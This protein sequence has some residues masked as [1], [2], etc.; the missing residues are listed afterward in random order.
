MTATNV[1]PVRRFLAALTAATGPVKRTK[2][3]WDGRCPVHDDQRA[4]LSISEGDDGKVILFCHVGCSPEAICGALGLRLGDLF[5]ERERPTKPREAVYA[6]RRADGTL[7]FEVVRRVPKSFLQRR[8]DGKGG[9]TW[10]LK[11]LSDE[12]R[13]LPFRLPEIAKAIAGGAEPE[14][15]IVEGEKDVLTLERLGRLATCNAQGAGKFTA[16][17]ARH[18]A[19]VGV[20]SARVIADRDGPGRR[21]AHDVVLRLRTAGITVEGY[22][23]AACSDSCKDASDLAL[24][25]GSDVGAWPLEWVPVPSSEDAHGGPPAV[26]AAPALRQNPSSGAKNGAST[27]PALLSGAASTSGP[28]PAL[29]ALGLLG[30]VAR[31]LARGLQVHEELALAVCLGALAIPCGLGASVEVMAG[32]REPAVIFALAIADPSERKT[33]LLDA[34]T[35]GLR[36]AERELRERRKAEIAQVKGKREA[37]EHARSMARKAGDLEALANVTAQL[38]ALE[39]PEPF[40][41]ITGSATG[42]ALEA[43]AGAQGGRIAIVT[44]E[45]GSLF[46]ALTRYQSSPNYDALLEGY[47]GRPFASE[48]VT[49]RPVVLDELRIPLV[50]TLQPAAWR[51]LRDDPAALGRGLLARFSLVEPP[52]M[53]G[54]RPHFVDGP[55]EALMARWAALLRSLMV[56]AYAEG[57]HVFRLTEGAVRILEPE[58]AR[59]DRLA[60][61]TDSGAL[62]WWY[63][64]SGG[65]V[66]RLA[67]VIGAGM[68]GRLGG[69]LG[70]YDVELAIQVGRWL[71][72]HALELLGGAATPK[73]SPDA[74]R[75]LTWGLGRESFTPREAIAALSRWNR[76]RFDAAIRELADAGLAEGTG[77]RPTRWEVR[78]A[79]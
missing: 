56:D 40:R 72:S 49:R 48:R 39:L 27:S 67:A 4:S 70:S 24:R 8:P 51:T 64:K 44:D 2:N 17:H 38:E 42:E 75:L 12:D 61:D 46:G 66:A 13:A 19:N 10:S 41:A 11:G 78:D 28:M 6:Y 7:V 22:A 3:G 79:E 50:G 34:A 18:L 52:S 60:R 47:D 76:P 45:A 36:E 74:R 20:R 37:L 77:Q 43:L 15:T 55:N 53:V 65:R 33:P 5:P 26:P 31:E 32:W 57:P 54:R 9:W 62:S 69:T 30:D 73:L 71:E 21:H 14:V 68:R 63:G 25:H 16:L 29:D 35:R 1:A 58:A 23:V 59:Y